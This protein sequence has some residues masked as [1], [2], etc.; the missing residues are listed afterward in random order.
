MQTIQQDS[1]L[2]IVHRHLES[3]GFSPILDTDVVRFLVIDA[4]ETVRLPCVV[5]LIE[6]MVNGQVYPI[7]MITCKV[8]IMGQ[9]DED[10]ITTFLFQTLD[11]NSEVGM[12][13][14]AMV[15]LS[16]RD[17]EDAAHPENFQLVLRNSINFQNAPVGCLEIAIGELRIALETSLSLRQAYNIKIAETATVNA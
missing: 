8:G 14:Y 6:K 13:P 11:M 4:D 10:E 1:T 12:T 15:V 17:G 16:D 2:E 3:M 7:L 9:I 5:N